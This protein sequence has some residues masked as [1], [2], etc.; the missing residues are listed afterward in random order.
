MATLKDRNFLIF[1]AIFSGFWFMFMQLWDLLPNFIDEWVDS[2][3]IAPFFGAISHGNVLA[4]GNVKPEMLINID[5]FAII[6]L[7]LVIAWL[8]GKVHPMIALIGGMIVSVIAFVAAGATP[9][10]WMVALFIFVFAIGEMMCSPKFSEYIGLTAPPDKKA[11]YMG[12]SNIPFAV[13]WGVGNLISGFL[14]ESLGSKVHFAREYLVHTLGMS[15]ADAAK[16]PQ[17]K[18]METLVS[19]MNGGKGAT[20]EEATRMLWDLHHPWKVW[21]ILGSVGLV[22]TVLMTAYY[23]KTRNTGI[24]SN[25][26]SGT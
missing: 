2:R 15:A 11:V 24:S 20:V 12:Y 1:L 8:T 10:G 19:M 5:S 16:I 3:D 13:G 7:M 17:E 6:A 25:Q 18:V 23:Y 21:A 26:S 22:A 9:I 4:S 14:Y